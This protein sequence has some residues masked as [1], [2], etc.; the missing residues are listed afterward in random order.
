M[1]ILSKIEEYIIKKIN[2]THNN[3]KKMTAF[4]FAYDPIDRKVPYDEL[5]L[6]RIADA[7]DAF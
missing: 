6:A 7:I 4:R 2:N 1:Y 5:T 3:R